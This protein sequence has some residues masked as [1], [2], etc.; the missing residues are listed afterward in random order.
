MAY[1]FY[2]IA[3][4]ANRKA[5]LAV[6]NGTISASQLSNA[7]E[8]IN[9]I[10]D[11]IYAR[12]YGDTTISVPVTFT[13]ASN[14]TV[15]PQPADPLTEPV[16][17]IELPIM[18]YSISQIIVDANGARQVTV[19]I[20]PLT[21]TSR[22]TDVDSDIPSCF[23]F[24]R[25]NP[26]GTIRFYEGAPSGEGEI[27]YSPLMVDVTANTDYKYFPRELRPYLIYQTAVN[28]AENLEF[29]TSVLETRANNAWNDFTDANYQ[30]S[31]YKPD[32]SA[33]GFSGDYGYN[34]L[35]G[36]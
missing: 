16:P 18:P 7:I 12:G 15:G 2:D 3:R 28:L 27:V 14:Y 9:L 32:A 29:D 8:E 21:Y 33:P 24:E 4:E 1:T 25:T 19:P 30:G 36:F 13:G 5:G 10:L 20:D 22:S 6:N 17:D 35:R 31:S 34:I 26:L 23:Y 11:T